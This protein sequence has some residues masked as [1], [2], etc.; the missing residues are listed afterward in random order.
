MLLQRAAQVSKKPR[1]DIF[2]V[3]GNQYGNLVSSFLIQVWDSIGAASLTLLD[4]V[5]FLQDRERLSDGLAADMVH[6]A[7]RR[8]RRE[9]ENRI[10]LVFLD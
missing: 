5:L 1:I 4:E 2:C 6:L 9:L 7:E 3:G 8:F 10:L